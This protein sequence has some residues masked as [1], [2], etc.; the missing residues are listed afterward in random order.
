[1]CQMSKVMDAL[2]YHVNERDIIISDEGQELENLFNYFM[3]S[4]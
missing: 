4:D 3:I 1:M 2:S